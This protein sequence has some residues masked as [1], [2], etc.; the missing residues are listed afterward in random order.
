MAFIFI[1]ISIGVPIFLLYTRK[2][3]WCSDKLRWAIT[4]T[5]FLIGIF[6]YLIEKESSIFSDGKLDF[7]NGCYFLFSPF[8]YN[9]FDRILKTISIK[10][11]NRDFY[12]FL[13]NSDEIDDTMFTSNPHIN[14][15][16]KLVSFLLLILILGLPFL[17]ILFF[18]NAL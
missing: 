5:L 10:K 6:G 7:H 14:W 12:L 1:C 8:I 11:Y 13:R 4:T 18:A 3:S 2:K 15:F 16:D 17:F 9:L